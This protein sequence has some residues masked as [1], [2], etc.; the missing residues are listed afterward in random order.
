MRPVT[1][2]VEL[3]KQLEIKPGTRVNWSEERGRLVILR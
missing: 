1:I 3:R 2:P